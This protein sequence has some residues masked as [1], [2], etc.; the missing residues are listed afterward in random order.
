MKRAE[1]S[2]LQETRM[3]VLDTETTGWEPTDQVIELAWKELYVAS[4]SSVASTKPGKRWQSLIK[5]SCPVS[6]EARAAHHITDAELANAEM[7]DRWIELY[8]LV[9]PAGLAVFQGEPEPVM[10]AHN[11]EFDV[12]LL[13]QSGVPENYLPRRRICTYRC[14]RHLYRDAPKYSNQVLR[15]FLNLEVPKLDG[16]PHRAMPDVEVTYALLVDMLKTTPVDRLIE[17]TNEPILLGICYIGESSGKPW[18]EVDEGLLRWVLAKG[19]ERPNPRGGRKI[20]FD[21]DTRHT[22]Q[23]WLAEKTKGSAGFTSRRG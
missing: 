19:P 3:V 4:P 18:S 11:L 22:C 1:K 2:G 17:L 10:V 13:L 23:H 16:P 6:V 5:P 21:A 9:Y 15:Y 20:G 14:A 8:E 7:M 12:R